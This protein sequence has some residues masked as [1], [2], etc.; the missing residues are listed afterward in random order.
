M[1]KRNQPAKNRKRAADDDSDMPEEDNLMT[2]QQKEEEAMIKHTFNFYL[3]G[4][5][6]VPIE[7]YELPMILDA[8]G[9]RL[10]DETL[11]K[12]YEMLEEKNIQKMDI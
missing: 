5:Q 8:C 7:R 2:D 4:K 3:M 1:N 10:P 11:R 6:G 12:I 9:Y